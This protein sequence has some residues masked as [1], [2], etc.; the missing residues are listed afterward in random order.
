ME[1]GLSK[2]VVYGLSVYG[3]F[4]VMRDTGYMQGLLN[5]LGL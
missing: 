1:N 5:A 4:A 2:V 3:M